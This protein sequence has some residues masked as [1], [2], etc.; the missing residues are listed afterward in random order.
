VTSLALC[1]VRTSPRA[2][3]ERLLPHLSREMERVL[4]EPAST[5]AAY[6]DATGLAHRRVRVWAGENAIEGIWR[7]L[8]LARGVGVVADDGTMKRVRLE[9]VRA[10]AA[11]EQ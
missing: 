9:H 11:A 7:E 3:L 4:H 8:D 10:L 2:V 6:F 1:G 5:L